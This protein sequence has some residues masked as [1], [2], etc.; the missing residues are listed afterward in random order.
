MTT[1]EIFTFIKWFLKLF[2]KKNNFPLKLYKKKNEF[3][4]LK[5]NICFILLLE[6]SFLCSQG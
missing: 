5:K 1:L 2:F 6:A 4:V 3:K